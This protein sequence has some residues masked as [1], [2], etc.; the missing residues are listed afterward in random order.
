MMIEPL[1][2]HP[3]G[4]C[5]T[6]YLVRHGR[7]Q[8][9]LE[10]LLH[11]STDLPLD[12]LG[13]R[14]SQRVAERLALHHPADVLVTS[15]LQRARTTAE[16]IGMRLGLSP[17]VVPG[18]VEMN[19]GDLEGVSFDELVAKHPEL[20]Q[21]ALDL[22]DWDLAWP[23]GESL[24]DFH[25]RVRRTFEEILASYPSHR[26]IV[27]AHGGVLGSFLAQVEG[28][29]PNDWRSYSLHNCSLTHVEITPHGVQIHTF[30]DCLHLDSLHEADEGDT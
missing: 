8:G 30:N 16:V 7:T 18:L 27:V 22:N 26:V 29:S 21:R 13:L 9:N 28:R 19:F 3:A 15:P 20:A 2:G 10:R 23:N 5:T 11:G 14:Q 4:G 25:G 24:R 6:L 1:A 17:L 12:G